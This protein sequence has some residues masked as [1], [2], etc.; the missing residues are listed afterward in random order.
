MVPKLSTTDD[1]LEPMTSDSRIYVAG[2]RTF[3][4]SAIV[5]RLTDEGFTNIIGDDQEPD[6]ADGAA[7]DRFFERAAP[8]YVI[9]AA[10]KTA[11][12]AGNVR[13][14]ADLMRDNLLVASHLIP[15][16]SRHR[17]KKL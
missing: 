16:A 15:A 17:V 14:S 9:V 8:E 12:I 6:V 10:G 5:K 7:V 2:A 4:G 11:G 13:W 3:I 1:K